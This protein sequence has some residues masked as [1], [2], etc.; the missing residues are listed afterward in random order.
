METINVVFYNHSIDRRVR[1][2]EDD[3]VLF[4]ITPT[5]YDDQDVSRSSSSITKETS[6]FDALNECVSVPSI[7][8]LVL[9]SRN[10]FGDNNN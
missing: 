7:D 5:Y 8:P 9:N 4:C 1:N 2:D 10:E 6:L 3:D